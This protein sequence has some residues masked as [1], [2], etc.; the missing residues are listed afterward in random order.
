MAIRVLVLEDDDELRTVLLSVLRSEGYEVVAASRGEEAVAHAVQQPF[1]LVVAD[2]RME[3]MDGLEAVARVRERSPETR[4]L[5]VTG[6]STEA[7]SIRAI[8]L[9]V[10][11]YLKKPFSRQDFLA[12]VRRLLAQRQEE[13]RREESERA[14]HRALLWAVETLARTL[15]AD[16]VGQEA[17][18]MARSMGMSEDAAASVQ[19]AALL[20][21]VGRFPG[22]PDVPPSIQRILRHV[23]ERWDGDGVPDALAG[24]AIPLESRVVA[25]ALYGDQESDPGRFDPT[26]LAARDGAGGEPP[27]PDKARA[28]R[29][30]LVSLARA[31]EES[32]SHDSA[33]HALEEAAADG[34]PSRDTVEALAGLARLSGELEPSRRSVAL[35]EQVGP[36][37]AAAALMESGLLHARLGR[38]S[39]AAELLQRSARLSGELRQEVGA[40]RARLA[41]ATLGEDPLPEQELEVMLRPEHA[42]ELAASAGW[43][44]PAALERP[45]PPHLRL[46]LVG[47]FP[48]E[49]GRALRGLSSQGR[50]T[51]A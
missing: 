6:Y 32:G 16:R 33:R 7:D 1:D 30:G 22:A 31:L 20:S 42:D 47:G 2:I 41:L 23:D 51:A 11:D 17:L 49:L 15:G 44:V 50:M 29:R 37:V 27:E 25:V 13:Q 18:K 28:R 38:P 48:R 46:R 36:G 40:A 45:T 26:V 8:Q 19:L 10:G 4:S 12:S 3:G 39:E 14:M 34:V 21:A 24:T 9:G 35:A 5:V 43:L